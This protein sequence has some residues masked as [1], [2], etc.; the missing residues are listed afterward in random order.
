MIYEIGFMSYSNER[1]KLGYI[2]LGK[3]G[4]NMVLHLLEQN[5]E[6][7]AWNRSPGPREEV[8]QAGAHTVETLEELVASLKAPRIIWVMLTAGEVTD[9]ILENLIPLVSKGDLIIDG[10]NSFYKDT[11]RRAKRLA[12]RSSEWGLFDDWWGKRGLRAS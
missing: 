5:V 12:Q 3:M 2:G 1:M 10:G 11:L 7:V 9:G 6:V 4:K 8:R